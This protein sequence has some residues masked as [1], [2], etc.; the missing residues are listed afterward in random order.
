[1][2]FIINK[3]PVY[4]PGVD[5]KIKSHAVICGIHVS[6]GSLCIRYPENSTSRP[7]PCNRLDCYLGIHIEIT[8]SLGVF[9]F[10]LFGSK[11]NTIV[12]VF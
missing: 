10:V 2:L 1:M 6:Y 12:H 8:E 3:T 9:I 5:I 4:I 11:G 7:V